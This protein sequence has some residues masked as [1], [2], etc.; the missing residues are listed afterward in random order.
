MSIWTLFC[1]F[2][3]VVL[4]LAK[5]TL[6]KAFGNF[7]GG[8]DSVPVAQLLSVVDLAGGEERLHT[9]R[10]LEIMDKDMDG[11]ITKEGWSCR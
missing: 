5:R 10:I 11:E 9:L 8:R 4:E 7:N 2:N 3:I 1:L 6:E